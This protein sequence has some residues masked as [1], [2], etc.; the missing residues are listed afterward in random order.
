[1]RA[2]G[3]ASV[4]PLPSTLLAEGA[5]QPFCLEMVANQAS[6]LVVVRWY[7]GVITAVD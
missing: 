3:A 4:L 7:S 6:H 2:G 1:M 5:D